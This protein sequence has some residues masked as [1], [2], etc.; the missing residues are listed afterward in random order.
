MQTVEAPRNF[1]STWPALPLDAWFD[2][3]NTLHRWTQIVGKI[4]L[5]LTPTVNHWWNVPLH[6]TSRGLATG[7]M[8]YGD[9]W[10]EME[11]Q[12]PRLRQT[13]CHAV[14]ADRR[15]H[16]RDPRDISSAVPR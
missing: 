1:S 4:Q 8:P 15:A 12:A 7:T 2:T 14:L 5:G 16:R 13:L 9:R 11:F 6:V 3:R 10:L